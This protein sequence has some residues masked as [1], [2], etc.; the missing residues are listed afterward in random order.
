MA[1]TLTNH[2][3]RIA[4]TRLGLSQADLARAGGIS[5]A[6]LIAI[7]D[8]RVLEPK[9]ETIQGLSQA[10]GVHP[11]ELSRRLVQWRKDHLAAA[12]ANLDP[13]QRALLSSSARQIRDH[14]TSFRRW[15]EQLAPSVRAFAILVGVNHSTLNRYEAGERTRE[16]LPQPLATALLSTL[17]LSPEYVLALQ[18]LPPNEGE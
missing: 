11:T 1:A 7:E 5:R 2:P 6:S 16:G 8:G 14:Q 13:S 3:L 12:L 18:E 17:N 10:L 4:R 15:R 9:P